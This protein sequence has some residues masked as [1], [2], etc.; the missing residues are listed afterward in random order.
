V[1]KPVPST[2]RTIITQIQ[3]HPN[4]V[5]TRTSPRNN[6][7]KNIHPR[8]FQRIILPKLILISLVVSFLPVKINLAF[9]S[10]RSPEQ[11]EKPRRVNLPYF[12]DS[13]HWERTAIF[14][15]GINEQGIPSKN[16]A[17]VRIGYSEFALEIQVTVIDY[18]LWY[19]PN[20]QTSDDLRQYEAVEIYL[21]TDHGQE[22]APQYDDYKFLLGSRH[23][24]DIENYQREARGSG[25]GWNDAWDGSWN[26][27]GYMSWE[28][29]GPNNNDGTIDYGWTAGYVIPWESLGYSGPP[30][31]GTLWGLGVQLFDRDDHPP[32]GAVDPEYW[33]ET[34]QSSNPSTWGEIHFGPATL[35]PSTATKT[36]QTIIRASSITDNS[37]EDAWMGGGGWCIG[38][39]KGGSEINYGDHPN[40][41]TGSE[42]AA[43]HFPCFN[44]SF[45]RFQLDTI[46][47]NV[48]IIS[49]TLTLHLFG[50]AAGLSPPF[51]WTHLF[52]ISDDWE[53]MT[54]HW[55]NAP[56]AQ[57]NLS[58]IKV[59]PYSLPEV[60]WPGDPYHWDAS[61]AVAEAYMAE[62]PANLALYSSDSGRDTS[63][64]FSSSETGDW[65]IEAR[66][67]LKV[68]WGHTYPLFNKF[69]SPRIVS[70]D[71]TATF[72][73]TWTGNGEILT[74]IDQLPAGVSI[75]H[76]LH[77]DI[78][79]ATY[80][81]ANHE[82]HWSGVPD[83]G[84]TVHLS[85]QVD[86][87]I[88]GPLILTNIGNLTDPSGPLSS[89]SYSLYVDPWVVNLPTTFR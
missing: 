8:S 85:Y 20:P 76:N 81:Q 57:E 82:I 36:G 71:D 5:L 34:F 79:V 78:G 29:G 74:L 32:A 9:T 84:E 15:F 38:G 59:Y 14:W 10:D 25:N 41:F 4:P 87:Q 63:K 53:E 58:V 21:D 22:D 67:T 80:N 68:A 18:Y 23:W 6:V 27:W 19:I 40:L 50:N 47:S 24:Q 54:I 7:S 13:I 70:R 69:G 43:T 77:V 12:E 51:S 60:N 1:I 48:E 44:K 31:E 64:Y 83:S 49:A 86:I 88:D 26:A 28:N 37:V 35:T 11:A 39:H 75:P 33:P 30:E 55:N 42:T 2:I 61:I 16:Y 66:P 62:K 73:L 72:D 46:P 3:I 65:N 52:K 17:D 56:L 89:D 45:L